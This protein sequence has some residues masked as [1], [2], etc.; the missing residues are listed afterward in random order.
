MSIRDLSDWLLRCR[1]QR[2]LSPRSGSSRL[3]NGHLFLDQSSR[4][5][6]ECENVV[7]PPGSGSH[8]LAVKNGL[9]YL[10]K[11]LF[12]LAMPD[13]STHANLV[14]RHSWT[15]LRDMIDAQVQ[16]PQPQIYSV[17]TVTV[18]KT[19]MAALSQVSS[20]EHFKPWKA[21]H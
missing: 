5:N 12:W 20:T 6:S 3:Q 14:S 15:E 4:P 1:S 9:P 2:F 18:P 19:P 8:Q 10:S 21:R 16:E 7:Y 11:E 17:K 13:I